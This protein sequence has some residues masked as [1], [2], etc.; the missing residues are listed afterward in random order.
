MADFFMIEAKGDSEADAKLAAL[1]EEQRRA[2]QQHM[3][4]ALLEERFKLK[5]H[6]E[7]REGDIYDLMVAKGGPKLGAEGSMAPSAEELK[8]FGTH[9][10]PPLNQKRDGQGFDFVAHGC[11]ME[12]L[13]RMLTA[14][15]GRRVV[16]KTDLTGKY[17]FVLKYLG[18]WDRDRPTDDMDPTPPMDRALQE[19]LGLKVEGAKGSIQVLVIDHIEKPS[20]KLKAIE[21]LPARA[22]EGLH[23]SNPRPSR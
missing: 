9:P 17:D 3:L 16:D 15:F 8:T 6:W 1:T 18:R 4:Q 23:P 21:K 12:Q 13:V 5:T 11:S 20:S 22:D 10:L 19:Q 14:Q 7:T 2:E